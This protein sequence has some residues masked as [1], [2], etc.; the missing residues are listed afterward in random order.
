[1]TIN[2]CWRLVNANIRCAHSSALPSADIS[3]YLRSI[4]VLPFFIQ[5][6]QNKYFILRGT[7]DASLQPGWELTHIN[8]RPI[9]SIAS[10]LRKHFWADGYNEIAKTQVVQGSTFV[11]STT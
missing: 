10:V 1:M 3:G 11:Y 9:D 6:V 8:G 7:G 5:P 2:A 4:K